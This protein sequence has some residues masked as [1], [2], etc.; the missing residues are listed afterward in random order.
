MVRH[1]WTEGDDVAALYLHKYGDGKATTVEQIAT[2][3]GISAASLK[4]R[5]GNFKALESGSGLRNW[6]HQSE[7]VFKKYGDLS[8]DELKT[9]MC[10]P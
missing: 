4:M 5:V 10:R 8:E 1:E 2:S 3:R 7:A 6:A 9:L